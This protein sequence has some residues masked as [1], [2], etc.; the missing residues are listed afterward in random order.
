MN[1]APY[2]VQKYSQFIQYSNN[3]WDTGSVHITFNESPEYFIQMLY[4]IDGEL[5]NKDNKILNIERK[6]L[7]LKIKI[8]KLKDGNYNI[9]LIIQSDNK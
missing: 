6:I 3:R 8:Q 4:E 7:P 5:V 9:S 2:D 1:K